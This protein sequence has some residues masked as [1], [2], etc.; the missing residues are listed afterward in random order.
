MGRVHTT[1]ML[2]SANCND[3]KKPKDEGRRAFVNL[4]GRSDT[5]HRLTP[6]QTT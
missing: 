4:R 6:N 2:G 5:L 3:V 1:K